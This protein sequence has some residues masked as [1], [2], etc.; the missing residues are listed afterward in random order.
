[1]TLENKA[2]L[3]TGSSRGIGRAIAL[4]FAQDGARVAVNCIKNRDKAEAVALEI[5]QNGG[6]AVVVQGDVSRRAD[7]DRLIAET[8]AAFG[9]VDIL[10]S[11]AGIVIDKPFLSSTAED[12]TAAMENNLHGFFNVCQAALPGM[13]ERGSGRIIATAA[14]I[15]AVADFG[16]N[17]FPVSAAPT[18]C[19][20]PMHRPLSAAAAPLAVTRQDGAPGYALS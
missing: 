10:V 8:T 6:E 7:A 17:C 9:A 2:A 3:V 14:I 11:N 15:T 12:W 18:G 4:R 19:T 5:N 1:M 16:G 13:I 20:S